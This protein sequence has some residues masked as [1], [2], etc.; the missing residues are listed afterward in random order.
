MEGKP[1]HAAADSYAFT[2]IDP[3][4]APRPDDT[5]NMPVSFK[6]SLALIFAVGCSM[7]WVIVTSTFVGRAD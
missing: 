5:I 1:E 4:V 3:A 2:V 6:L 7:L